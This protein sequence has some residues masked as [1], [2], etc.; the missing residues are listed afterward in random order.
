MTAVDPGMANGGFFDRLL[1]ALFVNEGEWLSPEEARRL[2][3]PSWRKGGT[4]LGITQATLDLL[5]PGKR[6]EDVDE[7]YARGFYFSW[8]WA[9]IRRLCTVSPPVAGLVFDAGVQHGPDLAVKMLQ[10]V[11]GVPRNHVD[12]KVGPETCG[13]VEKYGPVR[14]ILG[15]SSR[16]RALLVNWVLRDL[17]DRP[18]IGRD[19]LLAGVVKRVDKM[20]ALGFT[21]LLEDA[22]FERYCDLY[23][24]MH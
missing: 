7:E 4:M 11:V 18:G 2:G 13:H 20:E 21:L 24:P 19:E 5:D 10:Q 15:F 9:P 12:G 1:Q 22:P 6:A 8:Y 23:L 14:T 3:D 17:D 16:R